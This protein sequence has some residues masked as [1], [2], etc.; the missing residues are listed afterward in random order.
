LDI[1]V[2]GRSGWFSAG[3][4]DRKFRLTVEFSSLAEIDSNGGFVGVDVRHG[5]IIHN[6]PS[7]VNTTFEFENVLATRTV[8]DKLQSVGF[9]LVSSMISDSKM[10]ISIDSI[11]QKGAF[12]IGNEVYN[13]SVNDLKFGIRLNRWP[14]CNATSSNLDNTCLSNSGQRQQGAFIEMRI[15]IGNDIGAHALL[16][17]ELGTTPSIEFNGAKISIS[18]TILIDG[19]WQEMDEGYPQ[20]LN[21]IHGR[22]VVTIRVPRFD[23][24]MF[25]DPLV[26]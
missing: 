2:L 23:L 18:R 6:V 11:I 24:F 5:G 1:Y 22:A 10:I 21:D 9:D 3:V 26:E 8:G 25:Y 17:N 16:A 13:A 19:F 15:I 14:F 12:A 7:F 20:L 4:V